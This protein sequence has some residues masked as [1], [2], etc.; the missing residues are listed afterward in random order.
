MEEENKNEDI[1]NEGQVPPVPEIPAPDNGADVLDENSL[2]QINSEQIISKEQAQSIKEEIV[3]EI[4]PVDNTQVQEN[5]TP[6]EFE[7]ETVEQITQETAAK[8]Y[9]PEEPSLNPALFQEPQEEEFKDLKQASEKLSFESES[10]NNE[11]FKRVVAP[12]I[13]KTQNKNADLDL[14]TVSP[15]EFISFEDEGEHLSDDP[16]ANL[17]ILQD[18]KMRITVELGRARSS[19]KKILD[20]SKGSIVELNKVAGEQVELYANGKFIAYGEVIVIEDKFGL[21]VTNISH[22]NLHNLS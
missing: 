10:L 2:N 9:T 4:S 14:I 6:L 19:V 13:P 17:D 15:V 7:Q 11:G 3:E 16:K 22:Q 12:K 8:E 18:V 5:K 21:R 1:T 20:L